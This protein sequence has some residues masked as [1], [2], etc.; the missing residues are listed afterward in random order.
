VI[1]DFGLVW[2][3]KF[4]QEAALPFIVMSAHV[5]IQEDARTLAQVSQK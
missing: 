1:F 2:Y 4:D 5:G 3:W